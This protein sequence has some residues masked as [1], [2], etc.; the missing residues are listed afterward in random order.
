MRNKFRK[1]MYVKFAFKR[2]RPRIQGLLKTN[3]VLRLNMS[4]LKSHFLKKT[5]QI[6]ELISKIKI[7]MTTFRAVGYNKP[8]KRIQF[9]NNL[10]IQF[11]NIK[12]NLS[13]I[14]VGK[15]KF[16]NLWEKHRLLIKKFV[17]IKRKMKVS[18]LKLQRYKQIQRT[19]KYLI[20]K[21][22]IYLLEQVK[23]QN[24]LYRQR[25]FVLKRYK[26]RYRLLYLSLS[27]RFI[28]FRRR[29]HYMYIMSR[30]LQN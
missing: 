21:L 22:Y 8:I 3:K 28:K 6:K 5:F 30:M 26:K 2:L 23:L 27:N 4:L 16:L 12:N 17:K 19:F 13:Q 20:Y 15:S 10:K 18:T 7:F 9:I 25:F 11:L 14:N 24:K 29:L 1:L